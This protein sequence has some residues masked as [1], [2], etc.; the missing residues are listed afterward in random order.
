MPSTLGI[1]ASSVWT[2]ADLSPVLWLDASDTTTITVA[3]NKVSQW[4]DKSGNGRNFTQAT[5]ANQPS[6]GT[7]TQNGLNVVDFATGTFMSGGDIL[8]LGSNSFSTFA[9][10]KWDSST[11]GTPYGKHIYAGDDGRYGLFRYESITYSMYDQNA[12]SSGGVSVADSSTATRH[13]STVLFRNGTGTNASTHKLRL[14]GT[15]TSTSFTDVATSWN[16]NA[17]WQLG[18]YGTTNL[19]DFDGFVAELIV[20]LRTATADEITLT[21]AYLAAKWGT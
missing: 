6:S 21:E 4:N 13:V 7:R 16:T 19:L 18:R 12:T 3:S 8:D 5:S 15:E 20:V 14:A 2:P 17:S 10:V 11:V 9:V 1:V